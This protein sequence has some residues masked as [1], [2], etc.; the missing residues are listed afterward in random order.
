MLLAE[1]FHGAMALRNFSRNVGLIA[2]T[3]A[4]TRVTEKFLLF[5]AVPKNHGVLGPRHSN[6]SSNNNSNSKNNF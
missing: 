3:D 6:Y 5:S 4:L 2:Q 1:C